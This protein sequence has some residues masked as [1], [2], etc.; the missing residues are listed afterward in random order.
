MKK[1]C[2]RSQAFHIGGEGYC[3]DVLAKAAFVL[4]KAVLRY[5]FRFC[6]SPTNYSFRV[7]I[8]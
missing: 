6:L 1:A 5:G 7:E 2:E 3:K 8:A 4:A